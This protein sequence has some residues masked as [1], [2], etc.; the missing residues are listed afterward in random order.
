[1]KEDEF[2]LM[3]DIEEFYHTSIEELPARLDDLL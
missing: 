1:V 3:R 2:G